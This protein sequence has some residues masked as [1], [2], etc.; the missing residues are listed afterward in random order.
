MKQILAL[1]ALLILLPYGCLS[2]IAPIGD[3]TK[4]WIGSSIS[5]KREIAARPSSYASRTGWKEKTYQLGG[6]NWVYVEPV[7]P[8]CFVHWEVNPQ[9]IIVGYKLDGQRC[10]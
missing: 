8:D 1:I 6:G 2:Q 10:Y 9:G 3:F 4:G 7:R 5:E